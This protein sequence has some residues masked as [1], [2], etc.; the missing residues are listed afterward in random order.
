VRVQGELSPAGGGAI[1][2]KA[3]GEEVEFHLEREPL[4]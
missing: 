1:K 4:N 2:G 3:A